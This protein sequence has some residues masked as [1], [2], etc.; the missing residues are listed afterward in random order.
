MPQPSD[1]AA[2]LT[3]TQTRRQQ[4]LENLLQ[5]C[6]HLEPQLRDLNAHHSADRIAALVSEYDSLMA[7]IRNVFENDPDKA[8]NTLIEMLEKRSK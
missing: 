7:E 8:L 2:F 6:R 4:I 5:I 3:D 1:L